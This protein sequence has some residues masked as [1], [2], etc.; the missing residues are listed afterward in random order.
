[1]E[2]P[3]SK[4]NASHWALYELEKLGF[5]P[6]VVTQNVDMLHERVGHKN[7]VHFHGNIEEAKCE[8][9]ELVYKI[10]DLL[11]DLKALPPR[12]GTWLLSC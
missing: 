7:V 8:E 6:M 2:S 5:V 10:N 4:P 12:C 1:M 11:K 9:C 3:E